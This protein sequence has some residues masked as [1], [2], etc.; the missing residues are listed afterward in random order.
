MLKICNRL[1]IQKAFGLTNRDIE[2][3]DVYNIRLLL[4]WSFSIYYKFKII[5]QRVF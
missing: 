3:T 2:Q 1:K 4:N 5:G